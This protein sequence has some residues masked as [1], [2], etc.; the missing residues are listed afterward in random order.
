VIG[1][2]LG[3]YNNLVAGFYLEGD[4]DSTA[5]LGD[6]GELAA[7]TRIVHKIDGFNGAFDALWGDDANRCVLAIPH[8]DFGAALEQGHH[9]FGRFEGEGHADL[10]EGFG[11]DEVEIGVIAVEELKGLVPHEHLV[12]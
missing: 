11:V 2:V 12:E 8:F 10:F 5:G 6:D 3:V 9:G 1:K 7:V 4:D